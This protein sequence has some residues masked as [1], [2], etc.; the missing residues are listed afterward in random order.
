MKFNLNILNG[1]QEHG[2][3][4]ALYSHVFPNGRKF[5][6]SYVQ[7]AEQFG[8]GLACNSFIVYIPMGDHGDSWEVQNPIFKERFLDVLEWGDPE[9]L[10]EDILYPD[11][12]IELLQRAEP[13]AKSEQG[14]YLFWDIESGNGDEFDIYITDFKGLGF[15]RAAASLFGFFEKI[16][17]ASTYKDLLPFNQAPL[18]AEFLPLE[19]G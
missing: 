7:F 10:K 15:T 4:P 3:L 17:S 5:P 12:S 14:E 11:G 16:T 2:D 8:Y 18:P 19:K 6:A 1:R 9:E 13:F